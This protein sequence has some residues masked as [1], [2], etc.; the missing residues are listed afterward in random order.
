MPAPTEWRPGSA[1][2]TTKVVRTYR[3]R[4]G[5]FVNQRHRGYRCWIWRIGDDGKRVEEPGCFHQKRGAATRCAEVT[6]RRRN[7]EE[8]R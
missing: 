1:R 3:S 4:S 2:S 8:G 6:A 5:V 7:R